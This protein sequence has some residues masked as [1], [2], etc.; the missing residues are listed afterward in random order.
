[1]IILTKLN[2]TINE[3][4]DYESIII[5]FSCSFTGEESQEAQESQEG[6]EAQEEGSSKEAQ[7]SQEVQSQESQEIPKESS[8]EALKESSQEASKE[9]RK[10]QESRQ[11][12]EVGEEVQEVNGHYPQHDSCQ[13][14]SVQDHIFKV[15]VYLWTAFVDYSL[16]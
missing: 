10:A 16:G 4:H 8:Q 15:N 7:E 12:Q 6:K 11:I 3:Y 1:M 2:F 13:F 9:S 14:C 5:Y